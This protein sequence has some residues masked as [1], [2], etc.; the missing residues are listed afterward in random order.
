MDNWGKGKPR[1]R[2]TPEN[3]RKPFRWNLCSPHWERARVFPSLC[4]WL[5]DEVPIQW[6]ADFLQLIYDTPNLD[7]LLLTK[8]PEQWQRVGIVCGLDGL[9][10]NFN[11]WLAQWGKGNA[12]RNVWVGVSV[13]DQKRA[14]ERIPHLL[15][16]PAKLRFLSVEPLI[17]PME[18]TWC[19]GGWYAEQIAKGFPEPLASAV[20][21]CSD[22]DGVDWVIVGGESGLGA[23][24]C[25]IDWV[26]S[27]VSQCESASIPCF[28]KQLG[29]NCITDNANCEDWPDETVI[30]AQGFEGFPAGHIRLSKKGSDPSEWPEDLRVRQFPKVEE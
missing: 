21:D 11:I 18:I 16:I 22:V 12:P 24:P 7:W 23:R 9:E 19:L 27:I 4:D 14:E 29:Q 26:K 25:N 30:D 28:V 1:R 17:G 2:T 20:R 6:L 5:D 3:W 10:E 8:R 15:K 13:E